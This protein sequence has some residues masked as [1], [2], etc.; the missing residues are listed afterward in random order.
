MLF[1]AISFTELDQ[2]VSELL[3][4]L[5]MGIPQSSLDLL[6]RGGGKVEKDKILTC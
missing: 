2:K 6:V 4:H 1:L 3:V 5:R